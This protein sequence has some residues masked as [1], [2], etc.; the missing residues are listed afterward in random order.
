M[1]KTALKII[2]NQY[3]NTAPPSVRLAFRNTQ[4][5]AK[6]RTFFF[7]KNKQ[8]IVDFLKENFSDVDK[9]HFKFDKNLFCNCG[10]SPGYRVLIDNFKCESK[11]I[12]VSGFLKDKNEIRVIN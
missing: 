9:F 8:V 6:R 2:V 5:E 10:C 12:V 7:K 11:T 4:E 1:K 3:E